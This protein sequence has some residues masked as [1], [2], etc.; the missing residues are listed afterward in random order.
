MIITYCE[1]GAM[2]EDGIGRPAYGFAD[3]KS[4]CF[5]Y[6]PFLSSCGRFEVDPTE[7]YGISKDL[8]DSLCSLNRTIGLD[9]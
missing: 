6:N 7:A 4:G 3:V 8:A 1:D 9:V 5:I 2:T